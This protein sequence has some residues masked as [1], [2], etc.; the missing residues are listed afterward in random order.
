MVE[1]EFKVFAQKIATYFQGETSPEE[2][3]RIFFYKIYLNPNG[4]TLLHDMKPRK[5][6]GYFYGE[7]DIAI[8]AKKINKDLNS[9]YFE[10]FIDTETDDTIKGLCAAFSNECPEINNENFRQKLLR[11]LKRLLEMQRQQS[12]NS[13]QQHL[14]LSL[15]KQLQLQQCSLSK[16]GKFNCKLE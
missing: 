15:K 8:L 5:S 11:N 16:D 2:F 3:A 7:H 10:E 13:R 1:T 4:D 12:A 9:Q 14:L 6:R